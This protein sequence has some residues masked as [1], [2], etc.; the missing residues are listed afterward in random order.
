MAS[1]SSRPAL[2]RPEIIVIAVAIVI[3]LGWW[4]SR[5]KFRF[6]AAIPWSV[7]RRFGWRPH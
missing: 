6:Q 5:T 3:E 4:W 7:R 2:S 1:A